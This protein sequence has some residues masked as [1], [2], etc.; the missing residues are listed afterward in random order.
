[1]SAQLQEVVNFLSKYIESNNRKRQSVA[2]KASLSEVRG[3]CEVCK[4][5]LL[6]NLPITEQQ[7]R[8]L[9]VHKRKL[10][11]FADKSIKLKTKKKLLGQRGGWLGA[12]ASVALPFIAGLLKK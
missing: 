8:K 5:I 12:V 3:L 9:Q 6:G 1:M 10:R 7:K 11:K 4:N 2:R